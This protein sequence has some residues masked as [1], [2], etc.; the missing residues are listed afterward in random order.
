VPAVHTGPVTGLLAQL[1]LLA[2]LA[3]TVGLSGSGWVV[4]IA[5]AVITNALLARGLACFGT[6]RLGPAD[7]VTLARA[8]LAGGVAALIADAYAR[9]APVTTLVALTVVALVLDAV[10]GR[11]A[12]RTKTESTLGALFDGEV[13]AF[14]ILVLSVY[15]ARSA[16]AWVLAIGAAR[17]VFLAAGWLL[18]WMRRTLPPRYWRKVVAATQGVALTLAVSD[19]LPRIPT[20]TVLAVSLALLAESFGRDVGWLWRRRRVE[21]GRVMVSAGR[22]E[23]S[24]ERGHA[25]SRM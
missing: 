15:V 17:Y 24:G 23:P 19:V 14:L 6:D 2:A 3:G 7:W 4:G 5:C 25:L 12:R 16:G 20:S 22:P 11:V 10:D 13:D 8:T 18:P 1:V 21:G 9:T